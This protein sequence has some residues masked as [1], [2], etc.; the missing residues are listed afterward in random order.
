MF[1][2][3]YLYRLKCIV[4]DKQNMFWTLMFPILL[5][6]LF[7]MALSN[8][9]SAEKFSEIKIGI[10]KD[11]EYKKNTD[12]IK[13]IES[14]KSSNKSESNLFDIKYTSKK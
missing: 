10:V 8:I 1:F 6:T 13:V 5:A 12:F 9:S 14:V 7:N 3:N 11:D 2:H 4:R